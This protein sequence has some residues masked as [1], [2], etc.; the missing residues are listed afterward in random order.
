MLTNLAILTTG[1]LTVSVYDSVI[2][3]PLKVPYD[4]N[5]IQNEHSHNC[6]TEIT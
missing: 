6:Y 2:N 1:F 5:W 4:S 3:L